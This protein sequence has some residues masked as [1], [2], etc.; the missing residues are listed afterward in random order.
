MLERAFVGQLLGRIRSGQPL[1]QVILGPRQVGKTTGIHQCLSKIKE[2][3]IYAS[4]DD[5]MG[6]GKAWLDEQWLR[7]RSKGPHTLLVMD[8]IQKIENWSETVKK[9]WDHDSRSG[10]RLRVVLLGS[11]SLKLQ[12]GLTESLTGR[13]ELIKV[14]HWTFL[15]FEKAFGVSLD[16]YL[17][18]GGYPGSVPFMNE[19]ARWHA[20]IKDSVIETVINKDILHLR[21]VT[22]PALF[23][24]AFQLMCHF[25]AQEISYRKLLGQLHDKGNTDTIKHYLEL[26][27]GAFLFRS[28][29]KFSTNP[30][31]IKSSS[32]KILPL[33]PALFTFAE[34]ANRGLTREQRGRQMEAMVGAELN[35][36]EGD[37]YYWRD[38]KFEVDYVLKRGSKVFAIEVKSGR[39][40]GINGL[41]EFEKRHRKA[42]PILVDEENLRDFLKAPEMFLRKFE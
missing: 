18:F 32:P 9:H 23:R 2:P 1:I 42:I 6:A 8:E 17:C 29:Q 41:S 25:P 38:D 4:A 35:R 13:F 11:S 34:Y 16:D 14:Y 15:E 22:R 19:F 30:I 21:S 5:V 26:Y 27:E 40:Q 7:A 3:Y 28:L 36:L 37:L 39:K 24:Q 10:S 31:K 12:I 33:C 20:F